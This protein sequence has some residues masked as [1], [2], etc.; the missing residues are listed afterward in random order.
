M[1]LNHLNSYHEKRLP[2]MRTCMRSFQ[3]M[4][5]IHHMHAV[6]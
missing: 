2:R 3:L 5:V 6:A 1:H 4:S